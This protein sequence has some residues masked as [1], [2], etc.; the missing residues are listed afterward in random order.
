MAV[1]L[2]T[3]IKN[4]ILASGSIKSLLDDGFLTIFRGTAPADADASC[5]N[6]ALVIIRDNGQSVTAGNGLDFATS[7]LAGVLQKLTAQ[8]WKGT[9]DVTGTASF[10]RFHDKADGNSASTTADRIQGGCAVVGGDLNLSD[11]SLTAAADQTVDAYS[12][13]IL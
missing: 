9:N 4:N 1:K 8:T 2:S 11:L 3:G 13:V 6:T 12:V 7:G 5:G 10:Y